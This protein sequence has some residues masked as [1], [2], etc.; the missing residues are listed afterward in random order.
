MIYATFY[1]HSCSFQLKLLDTLDNVTP[2]RAKT[3]TRQIVD[4][5][6]SPEKF[7]CSLNYQVFTRKHSDRQYC[8][9]LLIKVNNTF[10]SVHKLM[11]MIWRVTTC[12]MKYPAW[13]WTHILNKTK[14][15]LCNC[16]DNIFV[17]ELGLT[18]QKPLVYSAK[19]WIYEW[20]GE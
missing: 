3:C 8:K 20:N 13:N 5:G 2:E 12:W 18:E 17:K 19:L 10:I 4:R 16:R 14:S 7:I 6:Y 15:V 9:T 1:L 11:M